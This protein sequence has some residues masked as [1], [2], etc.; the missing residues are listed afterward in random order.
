ML[1]LLPEITVIVTSLTA[2][3]VITIVGP[4]KIREF[5][6]K[7]LD[8]FQYVLPYLLLVGAVLFINSFL[9]DIGP[10]LSWMIGWR[11]TDD[12][13]LLEGNFVGW[14][15]TYSHPLADLYFSYI[16]IYGYI[17]MLVFPIVAYFVLTDDRPVREAAIAYALNYGIGLI[18][19]TLFIAYGPRNVIPD[20]VDQV[21]YLY[22]PESNMLTT[23]VNANVNVFPSLHTSLAVT[24]ALLAYRTRNE[25]PL[26]VPIAG[27][28]ALSV[29]FSTM[30]LGIHWLTDVIAGIALAVISVGAAMWF[31]SPA[32]KDGKLYTL[33]TYLRLPVDYPLQLVID[34]IRRRRPSSHKPSQTE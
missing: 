31:T 25:Y 6:A 9:R 32:R 1:P 15:Q 11:I 12:I 14:L 22:W 34:W 33:G 17:F 23:E 7:A 8:R 28:L 13:F 24:V 3:G 26:W 16:Y 5:R 18:C 4:T 19:Y 2:I 29:A 21:L 20:T 30:Y 27:L 10:T